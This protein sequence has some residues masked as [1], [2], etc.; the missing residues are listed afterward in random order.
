MACKRA[1]YGRVL[2]HKCANSV[3]H[4]L[5][6]PMKFLKVLCNPL[7]KLNAVMFGDYEAFDGE[8]DAEEEWGPNSV[9]P[10]FGAGHRGGGGGGGMY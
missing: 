4:V 7:Q 9:T 2:Q 6:R 5:K 8:G 10:R 1:A 3:H